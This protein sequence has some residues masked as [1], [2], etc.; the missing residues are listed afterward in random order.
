MKP[1][2][3][4]PLLL[5][6][7]I[8]PIGVL[9]AQSPT[10]FGTPS[11]LP[12]QDHYAAWQSS[13]ALPSQVATPTL[14]GPVNGQYAPSA[15]YDRAGQ[16]LQ[17]AAARKQTPAQPA[18]PPDAQNPLAQDA[19]QPVP[20][21]A[22]GV[23][24]ELG[25]TSFGN[26]DNGCG[27]GEPVCCQPC[28][29]PTWY[30]GVGGLVFTRNRPRF[31]QI[32]YD[33]TNLIGQVLST[34]TGLGQW[35]FGPQATIGWNI[36][37]GWALE[38]TYWGIY[39]DDTGAT[40][41][42]SQLAGNLNSALD[43]SPLNIGADNV[44]DLYD[45]AQ[46]H[47]ISR[48]Y[49]VNNFE[50][51]LIGGRWPQMDCDYFRASYLAGLRYLRFGEQFQYASADA[52]PVFDADPANEAYYDIDVRNNLWGFQLGG[53]A[54]W[55][56]TPQFSLYAAPKFG[57]YAN[58]MEQRSRIYN[59]N[60]VAVVGPGNPL[61]GGAYDIASDKTITSFIGELD[62]GLNYQFTECWSAA[63]GYRALAISG[64]AYAT[65]QIPSHFADLP[66]VV[67]IDDNSDMI[68]HGGYAAITL[69]W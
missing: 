37:P 11:L 12:T 54:D 41:Y 35:D 5:V 58:Y 9:R 53:R 66:G 46:A 39:A 18:V 45:A 19:L 17:F 57:I 61:A 28:C 8:F 23:Q 42:A 68:L 60:G 67:A 30:A 43:F 47:R 38:F 15:Y 48:D 40:V 16:P 69:T 10:P 21:G 22:S 7:I 33:D 50:L 3:V 62:L 55:Y 44:N 25:C 2:L 29:G 56:M 52:N 6:L 27:W 36:N 13:P 26:C 65:D 24:S 51:N 4:R 49:S 31:S 63:I 1:A 64:V 14:A 59:V 20:A 34:N 32:S